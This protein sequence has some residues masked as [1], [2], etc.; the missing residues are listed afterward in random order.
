MP[1]YRVF[2]CVVGRGC[3]L[4]SVHFLGKTL[5]VFALLHYVF[6]G[7]ICLLLQVFLDFLLLHSSQEFYFWPEYIWKIKWVNDPRQLVTL[8]SFFLD[9]KNWNKMKLN[10]LSNV[11]Y[12]RSSILRVVVMIKWQNAS[13]HSIHCL[14]NRKPL[15]MLAIFFFITRTLIWILMIKNQV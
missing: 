3:L 10:S 8:S 5:L 1:M 11:T 14:L 4:W 2:S 13:W 9:K 6:Q 12:W 15:Y 7:Q